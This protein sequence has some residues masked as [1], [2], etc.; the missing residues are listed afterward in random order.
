LFDP[1]GLIFVH[2]THEKSS[3]GS[4][5]SHRRPQVD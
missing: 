2:T 3:I 5:G 4:A 1:A